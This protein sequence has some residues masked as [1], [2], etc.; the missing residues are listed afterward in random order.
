MNMI[1]DVHAKIQQFLQAANQHSLTKEREQ[2]ALFYNKA[3]V[4][5]FIRDDPWHFLVMKPIPKHA[6]L[7]PPA[8]QICKGTRMHKK[9]L[10]KWKDIRDNDQPEAQ[11]EA[12]VVTALR[13]GIEEL[14]LQMDAIIS[15][16]D[17]GPY[18]FSSAVSSDDKHM[19]LFGAELT[20]PNALLP[21]YEITATTAD[22]SWMNSAQFET[23]G[24][25]DHKPIM[26]DIAK[27]LKEFYQ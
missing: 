27:R 8:F 16:V 25:A 6:H 14:G 13:E 3:G 1:N 10:G 9:K 18:T 17:M 4:I 23:Q 5:P 2:G 11:R 21:I 15:L 22:R 7:E 19:W 24:R 12:L 26:Q 20:S